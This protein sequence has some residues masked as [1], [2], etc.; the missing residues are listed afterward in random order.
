MVPLTLMENKV[1]QISTDLDDERKRCIRLQRDL[2]SMAV[3][4][5]LKKNEL[6]QF[7]EQKKELVNLSRV[8]SDRIVQLEEENLYQRSSKPDQIQPL[9]TDLMRDLDDKYRT[10][11]NKYN[12]LVSHIDK[13]GQVNKRP[14]KAPEYNDIFRRMFEVLSDSIDRNRPV[15]DLVRNKTDDHIQDETYS[16]SARKSPNRSL[17]LLANFW[18]ISETVLLVNSSIKKS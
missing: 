7:K 16:S 10:L 4:Y 1:N 3:D 18:E 13:N 15:R 9:K 14:S 6:N 11:Q 8:Q 5:E 17:P 12:K 2:E